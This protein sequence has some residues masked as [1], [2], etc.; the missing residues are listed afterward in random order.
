MKEERSCPTDQKC[1]TLAEGK[2]IVIFKFKINISKI[3][4]LNFYVKIK[5][6]ETFYKNHF[7]NKHNLLLLVIIFAIIIKIKNSIKISWKIKNEQPLES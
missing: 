5:I 1:R 2:S 4:I 3:K 6:F 7:L